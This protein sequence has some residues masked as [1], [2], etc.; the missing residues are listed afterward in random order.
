MSRSS[1]RMFWLLVLLA[2]LPSCNWDF[3]GVPYGFASPG[4]Q[5]V[6]KRFALGAEAIT[7]I[8][9]DGP[10]VVVSATDTD[11]IR[12]ERVDSS[13]VALHAIGL[14]TTTIQV[15]DEGQ[16]EDY[17][18]EVAAHERSEV[19]LVQRSLGPVP[20]VEIDET[21][22]VS[23]TPHQIVVALYDDEGLLFGTGLSELV[24]PERSEACAFDFGASFDGHCMVVEEGL[25]IMQVQVGGEEETV[26]LGAVAEQDILDLRVVASK[27]ERDAEAG[28]LIDVDLWGLT[29]RGRRVYGL[30]G[31]LV[32]PA[33][34]IPG[35]FSYEFEP[36]APVEL[37]S[38]EALGFERQLAIR[39][40]IRL[41]PGLRHACWSSALFSGC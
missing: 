21:I 11:V 19:L 35:A 32:A 28:E 13:H 23:D 31:Q 4:L 38:M 22:L 18:V 40:E 10:D 26:V 29:A 30:V 37:I 20:I 33:I 5:F 8:V 17:R 3:D 2:S 41:R 16:V 34:G 36:S 24:L 7:E 39:G 27:D 25:H 15:E 1:P 6:P 14:G 12:V 9:S